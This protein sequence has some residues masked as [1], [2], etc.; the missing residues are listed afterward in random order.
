MLAH[1]RTET[2]DCLDLHEIAGQIRD[3]KDMDL[4]RES[5]AHWGESLDQ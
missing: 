2:K 5:F 4:V 3:E 1:W